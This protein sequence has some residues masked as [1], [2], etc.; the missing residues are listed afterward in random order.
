MRE[1]EEAKRKAEEEEASRVFEEYVEDFAS[2]KKK[3][4][5]GF[6]RA[7]GSGGQ[8]YTPRAPK[9]FNEDEPRVSFT[10]SCQV[11]PHLCS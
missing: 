10:F 1:A 9:G 3:S 7:S 5:P 8:T 6:V 11:V 4:G 2:E